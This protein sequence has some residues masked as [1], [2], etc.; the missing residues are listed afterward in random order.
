MKIKNLIVLIVLISCCS[1]DNPNGIVERDGLIYK[2]DTDILFQGVRKEYYDDGTLAY[3]GQ[4]KDGVMN[5]HST[6][7]YE[8]GVL[9]TEGSMMNNKKEG[10]WKIYKESGD[11]EVLYH[12]Q[13]GLRQGLATYFFE[14]GT[15][16]GLYKFMKMGN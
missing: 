15:V 14:D 4:Y 16:S 11:L 1:P 13:D 10:D 8:T 12:Y 7:Y 3:E 5:G 2:I 6:S 9:K